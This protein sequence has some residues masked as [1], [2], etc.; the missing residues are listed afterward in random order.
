MRRR[1]LEYSFDLSKGGRIGAARLSTN[2]VRGNEDA[3]AMGPGLSGRT[4]VALPI[5]W[6]RLSIDLPTTS[7]A[8][9]LGAPARGP[10]S[11]GIGLFIGG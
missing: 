9:T 4:W 8:A 10:L 3:A 7:D 1:R 2:H 6:G 5:R 11:S